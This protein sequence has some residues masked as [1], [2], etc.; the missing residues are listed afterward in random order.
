MEENVIKGSYRKRIRKGS[1]SP[2]GAFILDD[3]HIQFS[4]SLPNAKYCDLYLFLGQEEKEV[5]KIEMDSKDKIG[6]IFSIIVPVEWK[7]GC[8]YLYAESGN[9]IV[10]PYA[11]LVSGRD[12]FG[13]PVDIGEEQL[14]RAVVGSQSFFVE[15]E[16]PMISF[17]D[18]ILYRMHIRGFTMDSSS[19]VKDRGTFRGAMEKIP[20]LKKLGINAVEIMPCYEFD[21]IE[22]MNPFMNKNISSSPTR[23]TVQ[24]YMRLNPDNWKLNYW[25]YTSN[26]NYFAP[27]LSYCA[28]QKNPAREMRDFIRTLHENGIEVILEMHFGYNT[29]QSMI[30]DCLHYWVNEFHVDGFRL[31]KEWIPMKLIAT[32]PYL[33][34]SKLFTSDWDVNYIYPEGY[35][36]EQRFLA[37]Y[38]DGFMVAARKFLKSD[39]ESVSSFLDCFKRN[40]REKASVHYLANNNGFTLMDMVSYD[41]KHNEANGENG[42]DGTDYNY[43]WNC[44]VEGKTRKKVIVELRKKQ[45]KN[46]M[47]M[48]FLSQGIPLINQGDEFLNSQGGNNNPYCL[49]NQVSWINWKDLKSN[50]WFYDY[51]QKLIAFRK[52]HKVFHM[53]NPFQNM[54]YI[55]CGCPDISFHS[56]RAWY[57][58]FANYSRELGVLFCGRYAKVSRTECDKDF[59]VVFNF[60]WEA[61]EFNLPNPLSSIKW[62]VVIDTSK[63]QIDELEE[64]FLEVTGKSYLVKERTIV[65]F[66]T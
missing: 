4:I 3:K 30:L 7:K 37:D 52:Q 54:D 35:E 55:S 46:A 10:D 19:K 16:R 48:L 53:D 9:Y 14:V 40:E 20:H 8:E 11:K 58:N 63:E 45:L 25:G 62:K 2:L 33:S 43:S 1:G 49:D 36:E 24:D 34:Q 66:S 23:P 65:V 13:K 26:A 44:G 29:N 61:H 51:V 18:M 56:C 41:I 57:P 6:S 5:V 64:G 17:S 15:E 28:D 12:I 27:K 32:D 38:H 39:E 22:R 47:L 21:E 50:Q 59:Y 31:N 42:M 60:H